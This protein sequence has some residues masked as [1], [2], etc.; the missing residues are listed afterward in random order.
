MHKSQTSIEMIS[1]IS[2]VRQR[3]NEHAIPKW[4]VGSRLIPADIFR[5]N[6]RRKT[7]RVHK[8]I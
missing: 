6:F 8:P 3:D 7:W 1:I 5:L 2:T 4:G